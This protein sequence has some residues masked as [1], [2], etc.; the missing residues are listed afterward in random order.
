MA[1]GIVFIGLGGYTLVFPNT[2]LIN[3]K[4]MVD[5]ATGSGQSY[6]MMAFGVLCLLSGIAYKRR[7]R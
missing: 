6:A 2:S 3:S 1:V 4:Q 5:F 7:K